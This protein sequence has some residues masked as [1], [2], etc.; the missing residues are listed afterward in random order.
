M[1]EIRK[2]DL[3]ALMLGKEIGEVQRTGQ[4]A[5]TEGKLRWLVFLAATLYWAAGMATGPAWNTC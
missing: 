1:A 3:V 4:T 5:F 2:L